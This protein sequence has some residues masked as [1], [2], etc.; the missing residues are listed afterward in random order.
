MKERIRKVMER[1]GMS[2]KD[3][4][5]AIGISQS[6]LSSI[7]NG[8]TQTTSRLIEAIHKR[9]PDISTNWMM[10]GEGDMSMD[11]QAVQET[12]EAATGKS[13]ISGEGVRQKDADSTLF[14]SGQPAVGDAAHPEAFQQA[15]TIVRE[16]IK[17]V[18]KPQRRVREIQVIYDDGMLETFVLKTDK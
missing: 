3:F 16:I 17:Y 9:F 18:D 12:S 5:E 1:E 10:F 14:D 11:G 8:R 2:Q 4:S 15:P 13:G 7:L 6:S